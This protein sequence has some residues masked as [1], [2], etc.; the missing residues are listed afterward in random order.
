MKV[1]FDE[2]IYQITLRFDAS[3]TPAEAR[4]LSGT[5]EEKK[6]ATW[7]CECLSDCAI[8]HEKIERIQ[9][10]QS[11]DSNTILRVVRGVAIPAIMIVVRPLFGM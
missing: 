7:L 2:L 10:I 6:D 11:V 1:D 5:T 4:A 9:D 8:D 3:I